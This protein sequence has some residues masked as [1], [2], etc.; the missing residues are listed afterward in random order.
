MET[1]EFSA[2]DIQRDNEDLVINNNSY[3]LIDTCQ[4]LDLKIVKGRFGFDQGIRRFTCYS[5][6][7][8]SVVDFAVVSACLLPQI[9]H[10]SVEALDKC[11]SDVH[12]L[13]SLTRNSFDSANYDFQTDT[14]DN[15]SGNDYIDTS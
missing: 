9:I 5:F 2:G 8:I 10:F 6:N 4:S 11:L 13:V 14:D 1:N 7:G 12:C 15:N 3:N